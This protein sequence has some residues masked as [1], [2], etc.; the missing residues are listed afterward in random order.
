MVPVSGSKVRARVA[1]GVPRG[2]GGIQQRW[3]RAAAKAQAATLGFGAPAPAV[4]SVDSFLEGL[5]KSKTH[6]WKKR[7]ETQ[8]DEGPRNF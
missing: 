5:G 4:A 7:G 1:G 8:E 6:V 3:R 2:R